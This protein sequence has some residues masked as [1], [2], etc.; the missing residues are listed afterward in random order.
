MKNLG[1][2]FFA[3]GIIDYVQVKSSKQTGLKAYRDFN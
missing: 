2:N 3:E 1:G